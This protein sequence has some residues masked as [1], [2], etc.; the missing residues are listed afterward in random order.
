MPYS[1][2]FV[3]AFCYAAEAHKDQARKAGNVPYINHLMAVAAIVGENGGTED[4][5]IAALL[6]DAPEDQG[7]E[8]RLH[9]I[10]QK[11]GDAVADIVRDCTD[12]FATP[13]PP[14]RARKEAYI[15]HLATVTEPV[16]LV[17]AADKLHNAR[18]IVADLRR[19]GE[20]VFERFSGK[21]DGTLWY[22]RA[23][24]EALEARRRT[25]LTDELR[26]TVAEIHE[27]AGSKLF[28]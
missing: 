23:I 13:K 5:V 15:A 9:D 27:L 25:P 21:K 2:R 20:S 19:D 3:E 1:A 14:W 17:S 26:R 6:H 4:Q 22:Y 28:K 10:R 7:G 8:P 16:L 12:T 24:T 11:F 18:S